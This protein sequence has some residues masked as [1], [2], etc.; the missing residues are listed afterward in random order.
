MVR[1]LALLPRY[2]EEA[3]P[4]GG[5][6]LPHPLLSSVGVRSDPH[7]HALVVIAATY[8]STSA[9]ISGAAG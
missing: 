5:C 6:P 7:A 9:G 8:C 4:A 3:A 1:E 2:P